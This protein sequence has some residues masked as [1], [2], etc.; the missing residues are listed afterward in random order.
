MA[1]ERLEDKIVKVLEASDQNSL[2]SWELANAIW[3]NCMHTPQPGNGC[4]VAHIGRAAR[5]STKLN[6]FIDS[7]DALFVCLKK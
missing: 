5:E 2:S 3:D 4:K 1:K 6:V 7:N